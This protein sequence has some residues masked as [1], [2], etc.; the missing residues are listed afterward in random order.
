MVPGLY[1]PAS[2]GAVWLNSPNPLAPPRIDFRFLSEES[3]RRRLREGVRLATQLAAE[4]ALGSLLADPGP[5]AAA[6][7]SDDRSLDRWMLRTVRNS[8]HPAG[9]CRM[10]PMSDPD[11]VVDAGG[12][13]RGLDNVHIADA[14]VFP[15]PVRAHINATTIV[16]A[17]RI[18]AG[19][20]SG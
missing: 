13:V 2:R 11:A 17:E 4:H 1:H 6:A 5:S 8:Q 20:A 3:D 14:S 10:G 7:F 9:T 18:A 12:A 19:L 15:G 16:V